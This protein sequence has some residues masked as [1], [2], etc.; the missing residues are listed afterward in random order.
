MANDLNQCNMIGRAGRDCELRFTQS[1]KPVANFSMAVGR[2]W[3]DKNGEKS[4]QT[5]WFNVVIFGKLGEQVAAKF[6]TKGT[7]LFISGRLQIRKYQNTNGED[8]YSTEIVADTLQLLDSK[9]QGQH[10]QS[11]AQSNVGPHEAK[12]QQEQA[13]FEEPVFNPEDEIPF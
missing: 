3:K 12:R 10:Q 1:G 7:K 9:P 4:E 2:S 13:G 5:E 11:P 6:V 8:K